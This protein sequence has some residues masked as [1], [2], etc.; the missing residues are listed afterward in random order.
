MHFQVREYETAYTLLT[1]RLAGYAAVA[2]VAYDASRY[3][4]TGSW[5]DFDN[6]DDIPEL[7]NKSKLYSATF[8]TGMAFIFG[9]YLFD[10]I[11]GRY[12]LQHKQDLIRYKYSMKLKLQ[13]SII[14]LPDNTKSAVPMFG[15]NIRF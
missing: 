15:V 14:T 3:V 10:W 1:I 4:D 9:S 2:Y 6:Y 11:H 5:F 8:V 7:K 13:S 12:R